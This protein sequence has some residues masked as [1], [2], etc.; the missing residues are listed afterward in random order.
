MLG[1]EPVAESV[2]DRLVGHHPGMPCTGQAQQT[3]GTARGLVHDLHVSRM[4]RPAASGM[5]SN[6]ALQLA[7]I[8]ARPT[9][10]RPLGLMTSP[11]LVYQLCSYE[12]WR[13]HFGRDDLE[14]GHPS[15]VPI[16]C[17]RRLSGLPWRP[18]MIG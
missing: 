4:A 8:C 9:N 1:M 14:Y 10:A 16:E 12:H 13:Q 15:S 6:M 7:S 2:A 11:G 17:S 5:P 3:V 18:S